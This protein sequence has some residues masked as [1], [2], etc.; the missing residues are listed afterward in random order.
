MKTQSQKSI[1]QKEKPKT[2]HNCR[3]LPSSYLKVLSAG[4]SHLS[5][6]F[7]VVCTIVL[8]LVL[9][10]SLLIFVLL[11]LLLSCAC[12]FTWKM[13][14]HFTYLHPFA[15]FICD[16]FLTCTINFVWLCDGAIARWGK[17]W[18]GLL[19]IHRRGRWRVV[20]TSCCC[21]GQNVATTSAL[22]FSLS[23]SFS[24]IIFFLLSF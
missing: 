14:Y 9:L 21:N 11:L 8:R 12:H 22:S 4:W 20:T 23:I 16:D 1:H 19:N 2:I 13:H 17:N 18:W 7:F 15:P 24:F 10:S 6:Y 5:H 3:F